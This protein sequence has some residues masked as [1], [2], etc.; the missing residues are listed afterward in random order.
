MWNAK[1]RISGNT[2]DITDCQNI[3]FVIQ[4]TSG[5]YQAF[6]A[7]NKPLNSP[8]STLNEACDKLAEKALTSR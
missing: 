5:K 7:D 2:W 4:R 6:I 3:G 1:A 8:V